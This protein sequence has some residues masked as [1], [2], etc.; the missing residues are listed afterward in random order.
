MKNLLLLF[1]L[2]IVARATVAQQNYND[3]EGAKVSYFGFYSGTLDS[4]SLNPLVAGNDTS[5]H[6]AKY[7]RDNAT[8]YDNLQIRPS[9]KLV[10]VT[11]YANG[12]LMAS[13]IT[14]KLYST[15]P[16]GTQIQ[17]QLGNS[18][19]P[20]YPAGVH[21]EYAAV[22]TMQNAWQ[23]VTFNFVQL[24]PGGTVAANNIDKI[25]MLFHPNSNSND[26]I[27]F[28]D[29]TG[30]AIAPVSVPV[31]DNLPPF[32][33]YQNNPNPAKD[34]THINFQLNTSGEVSLKLYDMLGNPVVSIVE[35]NMRAGTYAIPVETGG[36]PNGIYFYVLKKDNASRS[37]KLIVSK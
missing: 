13:K 25:V 28:D 10:D 16:V 20:S 21:S 3:F 34:L 29:L 31:V 11:P 18:S 4:M 32:K 33:L 2:F 14:M 8:L 30:P 36:L 27:Y 19:I 24:T 26:T 23:N 1:L 22:T 15:A 37:M 9:N 5:M 35:Q 12:G 6:C 17:L 7:V